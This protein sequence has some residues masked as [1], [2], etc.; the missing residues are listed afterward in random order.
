VIGLGLLE[1]IPE[2]TLLERA[3]PADCNQDGISGRALL[4]TDPEGGKLRLGR[5]GWKAEKVSVRHQ[6]LDAL[7]GDLG[8]GSSARP[9]S[10]GKVELTSVEV[11]D[12]TTYMRLV[13]V[14]A[15]RDVE[16]ALVRSGEGLF[17]SVGCANC[18]QT[19]AVT[20]SVHPFAE[21]R[22][23]AIKPYTDLLLHDM[24]EGLAD[25]SGVALSDDPLAPPAA[26]EWRTPPLWGLGLHSVVN[27]NTG[28]LHD[29][30]AATPLEA[31]LWHGGEA[32]G[33]RDRFVALSSSER[34]ALLAF[35]E[36]L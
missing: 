3:D 21:L 25:A 4:V 35:L 27:G 12:L 16:T 14:P 22:G 33:A 10:A 5:F 24:G 34:S 17:R 18:H 31:I 32:Q 26:Q 6:V 23:Q 2:A 13:S 20:G 7:E 15:Q 8:V 29:G 1:A 9:D 36:S 11:A 30:R 28:L 19:D